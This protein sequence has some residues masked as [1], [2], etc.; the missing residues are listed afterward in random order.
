MAVVTHNRESFV[1]VWEPTLKE[2]VPPPPPSHHHHHHFPC[3]LG[4]PS[5]SAAQVSHPGGPLVSLT[6][7][8]I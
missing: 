6:Q 1:V 3:P 4:Q 7:L 8:L 2:A 5:P